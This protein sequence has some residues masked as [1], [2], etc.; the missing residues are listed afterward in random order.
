MPRRAVC[1]RPGNDPDLPRISDNLGALAAAAKRFGLT[2]ALEAPHTRLEVKTLSLA[3]DLIAASG[4]DNA[5]IV[6]DTNQFAKAGHTADLLT[7]CDPRLFPYCQ[8]TD[9]RPSEAVSCG[10]GQGTVPNAEIL[11]AL[12]P[13][14]GLSG[15]WLHPAVRP[16]PWRSGWRPSTTR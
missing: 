16:T 14:L 9:S 13:G 4:A 10:P 15:E 6:L 8:L 1:A 5:V 7:H 3:L 11:A 12:P 2:V